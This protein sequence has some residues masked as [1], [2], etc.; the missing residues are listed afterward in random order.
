MPGSM[1]G[2][3]EFTFTKK[4]ILKLRKVKTWPQVLQLTSAGP[5]LRSAKLEG[6][7]TLLRHHATLFP[8]RVT[9]VCRGTGQRVC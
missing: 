8:K 3:T 6:L 7:Q 5:T 1:Q 4:L 2:T 9:A